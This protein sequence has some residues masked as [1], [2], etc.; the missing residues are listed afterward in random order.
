[1]YVKQIACFA[2]SRK[3]LGRC[4]AGKQI[5][6]GAA[7]LWIRPVGE[8]ATQE[9]SDS[10]CR[11]QDGS[12]PELLDVIRIPL[13]SPAPH[14]HQTENHLIDTGYYWV[15]TGKLG[16]DDL[17][18]FVDGSAGLWDSGDSSR[19]GV[20]DRV[21]MKLAEKAGHSL[22]L[23]RPEAC[24]I[25]VALEES[26]PAA[27]RARVRAQF[28]YRRTAYRLSVTDP[29]MEDAFGSRALG[30][31]AI[32]ECVMCVSLG[33]CFRDRFCYKLCAAIITPQR[34]GTR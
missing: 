5:G 18:K 7:P 33:E 31:Y 30:E 34:A 12:H 26:S 14:A 9:I 2:Y 25:V 22:L 16:W 10:E 13:K 1:M 20:N 6:S 28:Q 15:R 19:R 17:R 27:R 4:V 21:P 3:N 8:R 24:S 32:A 23:I 29:E 11:Y